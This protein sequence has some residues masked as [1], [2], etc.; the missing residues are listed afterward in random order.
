MLSALKSLSKRSVWQGYFLAFLTAVVMLMIFSFTSTSTVRAT[1]PIWI[2][3]TILRCI[4]D[5]AIL[6][7]PFW[8]LPKKLRWLELVLL[9][10][11]GIWMSASLIYFNVLGDLMPLDAIL[12]WENMDSSVTS[13]IIPNLDFLIISL[14]VLPL[15][16]LIVYLSYFHKRIKN[17]KQGKQV[18]LANIIYSL[19]LCLLCIGGVIEY[20]YRHK[21]LS[22]NF[23]FNQRQTRGD[24]ILE[25]LT[26]S[27]TR[28]GDLYKL[29]F[30]ACMLRQSVI[31]IS[32]LFSKR[33]ISDAARHIIDDYILQ[34]KTGEPFAQV[35]PQNRGKNLIFIIVESLNAWVL[36][37]IHGPYVM[38]NLY[39]MIGDTGTVACLNVTPQ[40]CSGV[41]ADGQMIY[42]TGLLPLKNVVASMQFYANTYPTLASSLGR[43]SFEVICENPGLWNH[44]RSTKTY[45][46]DR[47]YSFKDVHE[48][49]GVAPDD[50]L[51]LKKTA[52][53]IADTDCPYFAQITTMSMHVPFSQASICKSVEW[54]NNQKS[55]QEYKDYLTTCHAFDTAFGDFVR[56]LKD[57]GEWDNTI[58]AIASDHHILVHD[59]SVDQTK[60]PIVFAAFNTGL[61]KQ[62]KA[63]VG[64]IDVFPTLLDLMGCDPN[65]LQWTGLGH[66]FLTDSVTASVSPLEELIGT[67]TP[68]NEKHLRQAWNVSELIIRGDYWAQKKEIDN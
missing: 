21:T 65:Q 23:G 27:T 20:S 59:P 57:T 26:K 36:D 55:T 53:L 48:N 58:V 44:N 13:N 25:K 30:N 22:E 16:S 43:Y 29:G 3:W 33:E 2:S 15:C 38:P 24:F 11:L 54:I 14:C 18:K 9:L 56:H 49:A 52:E 34:A 42:N 66:S 45:H 28:V 8:L 62:I 6:T 12:L 46:Y 4:I 63:P 10:I 32:N 41:S 37:S 40:I 51:V 67:T 31:L 61:T 50:N 1:L 35:S 7:I 64:Q 60:A 47:L 5:A 17:E 68:D 39:K 19:I